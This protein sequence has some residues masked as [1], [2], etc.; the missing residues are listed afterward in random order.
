MRAFSWPDGFPSHVNAQTPGA[1]HEGGELGYALAVAYG[2]VMDSPDLINVCV[3]GDGESETGPTATAW[4]A[5][6]FIDPKESGAVIPILHCNG[7]KIAERTLPGTMDDL[8]LALLYSGYGYQVMFVEY[9]SEGPPTMG[10]KDP[11]DR[12][13]HAKFSVALDWAVSEVRKIQD[14]ARSGKPID[15]PRWPM[16]IL[17]SPKGWSGPLHTDKGV[18]LLNSYKSHQVPL[19]S[20]FS[21]PA[22]LDMLDEWLR[23]YEPDKFFDCSP[24]K[25]ASDPTDFLK[26]EATAI[27]PKDDERKLGL[28]KE[29]YAAYEPLKCGDWQPLG[30]KK[31]E[32]ISAMHAAGRYIRDTMKANPHSLRIFSPDELASNKLDDVFEVTHRNFQ[33]DPETAHDGGRVIEMLSEHT[34]Q[35]FLQGYVLTGRHA[36]F[37][38][39]ESFAMIVSTMVIQFAKFKHIASTTSWRRPLPAATYVE[40]STWTRQEHNGHSHQNPGFI[41]TILDLPREFARVYFPADANTSLSVMAHCLQSKNYINLIVGT[42][43]PAPV[44]LSVE[45]AEKHCVAGA[46]VWEEYSTN[47]GADP[48]VVLCG[49]GFEL[50]YEVVAAAQLLRKEFGDQLRVRVVNVVDLL[51]LAAPGHHPH[52]LDENG[53]NSLFPPG[54]P[55]IMNYH[56][57]PSQLRNLLFDRKH[58]VGRSRFWINGYREQGTTTTPFSMLRLN[59]CGRFDVMQQAL[60]YVQH[61]FY[62]T[63]NIPLG[64]AKRERLAKVMINSQEFIAG[65]AHKNREM[66]KYAND[67]QKDHPDLAKITA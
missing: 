49:I 44:L 56:G 47:K 46:S 6:K 45:E 27:V 14:A 20:A 19:T 43:N 13:L 39:Y 22:Q 4:H 64:S 7:F 42:K 50:T 37:P 10:G 57:Y 18:Q 21:D 25:S 1:I 2:S 41:Q 11:A 35:G 23:S 54:V 5:H 33:W 61:N 60:S 58:S 51:I 30:Y 40:T 28:L 26:P 63:G 48:D 65:C 12:D 3:V 55:I 38:T 62:S 16:L 15:K 36:I 32:E 66:E 59:Q 34:L 67:T 29:T 53:F 9:E 52:A 8:E 31:G 17:R 24:N